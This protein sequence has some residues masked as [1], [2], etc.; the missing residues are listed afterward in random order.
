MAPRLVMPCRRTNVKCAIINAIIAL[1][2]IIAL[3]LAL[4]NPVR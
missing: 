1:A 4:A 2:G 3:I